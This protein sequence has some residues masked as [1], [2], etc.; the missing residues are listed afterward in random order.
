MGKGHVADANELAGE[1]PG[2][3]GVGGEVGQGLRPQVVE[4]QEEGRV[5]GGRGGG[6]GAS[7]VVGGGLARRGREHGEGHV[8]ALQEAV[9]GRG[10]YGGRWGAH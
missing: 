8:E 5:Q 7:V 4:T 1:G 9:E 3:R 2:I 6:K 10:G